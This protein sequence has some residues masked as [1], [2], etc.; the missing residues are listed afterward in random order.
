M[1]ENN[2]WNPGTRYVM[3]RCRFDRDA[4]TLSPTETRQRMKA[5]GFELIDTRYLFFFP[6]FLA[7]FRP[8]EPWLS[9]VPMGAQYVVLGRVPEPTKP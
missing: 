9:A 1:Y 7:W 4:I 6:S 3:S 2:P 5:A 8:L